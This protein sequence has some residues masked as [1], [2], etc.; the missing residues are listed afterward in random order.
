M[1]HGAMVVSYGGA[2]LR[3]ASAEPLA[4]YD[5][6]NATARGIDMRS[7]GALVP[8]LLW[9][10]SSGAAAE[11]HCLCVDGAPQTVCPEAEQL[12]G[13]GDLCRLRQPT[14]ACPQ[15]V[16]PA[17]AQRYEAPHDGAANCRDADVQDP[18]SGERIVARVCDMRPHG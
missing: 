10:V 1:A 18:V 5:S 12:S 9:L 3:L 15:A 17:D 14:P 4:E 7:P 8:A 2:L 11:C 13:A 16:P 6:G